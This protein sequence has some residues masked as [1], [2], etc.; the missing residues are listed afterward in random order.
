MCVDPIFIVGTERSGSNLL[1]QMLDAHSD[2]AVPHPP[3]V[4]R[5]FAPLER[6]YGDLRLDANLRCLAADVAWLV[7]R[8]IYPWP[9]AVDEA[10]LVRDARWRDLFGLYAALYDQYAAAMKK[11][12]W[13]C[14]STFMVHFV[15][16][17]VE[18]YPSA[19]IIWLVRDPRDV[20]ASSQRSVFNPCH[21]YRTALLWK[22]QQDLARRFEAV[23]RPENLLRMHYE[24]L[25]TSPAE[26]LQA[27]CRFVGVEFEPRML[28][29]FERDEARRS[30]SLASDWRNTARPV[31]A[32]NVKT[33]SKLLSP[34]SVAMVEAAAGDT[35]EALGYRVESSAAAYRPGVVGRAR[36][37]LAS[38]V[39]RT[40]VECR[41]ILRDRNVWRRWGRWVAL[42]VIVV[43][44]RLRYWMWH[45]RSAR[46][47]AETAGTPR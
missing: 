42:R 12:R 41:S 3:H 8:H 47:Y 24:A 36:I 15:D 35:M 26:T 5:Y 38:A 40:T 25:V 16:R 28:S 43:R 30:A 31:M 9:F 20:A 13:C 19:R 33:F 18:R 17:I 4:L 1:R 46:P 22:E 10:A 21:P 7:R 11:R 34:R 45:R 2:I 44:A 32:T 6:Y 14:K 27:I 29:F 23:L 37:L 39:V